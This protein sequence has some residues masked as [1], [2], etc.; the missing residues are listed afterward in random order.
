MSRYLFAPQ[1]VDDY[2][3]NVRFQLDN[4]EGYVLIAGDRKEVLT[5]A[6]I[7][8]ECLLRAAEALLAKLEA[9]CR[10]GGQS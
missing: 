10:E 4:V 8:A 6:R 2:I 5:P 7:K 9:E 3:G 1:T